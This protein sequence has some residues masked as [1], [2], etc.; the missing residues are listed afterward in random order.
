MQEL[1]LID[2]SIVT[3]NSS[4]WLD[5]FFESLVK[6]NYP[7]DKI[8]IY[9]RDNGSTDNTFEFCEVI[10]KQYANDFHVIKLSQ[11]KN[12]GFGYGHNTNLKISDS[13]Y[14]LVTNVDL[15][16]EFNSIQEIVITALRDSCN[17]ASWEFR[18][19]PYEHPKYYNPVTLE[20]C[21]SSSACILFR[22]SALEKVGGYEKR[23][24]M[25]GEDVELSYRLRDKGYKLKYCPKAVCWHYTYDENQFKLVQFHGSTLANIYIRIRYGTYSEIVKAILMYLK[26]FIYHCGVIKKVGLYRRSYLWYL[27]KSYI[28]RVF[29]VPI[30]SLSNSSRKENWKKIKSN[31]SILQGL[32][33]NG[34]KLFINA[35]YFFLTRKKSQ[36]YFP[37]SAW[38]YELNR[39]GA[40]YYH[41][42]YQ[43]KILPLVSI[44]VRTYK[45]RLNN[46]LEAV[47][48]ILN[49]TYSNLELIVIEDGSSEAEEN[50][51]QIKSKNI[52]NKVIYESIPKSGRCI[53]GNRGLEL[54]NGDYICFLDDDDLFF[55]DHVETLAGELISNKNIA[56]VYSLAFQIG[57]N[58][59][60]ATTIGGKEINSKIPYKKKFSRPLLWHSNFIP[61]QSLLFKKEL[62]K[63]YG[64]F[65]SSLEYLE[66]WNLWV[67]YSLKHD[68]ILVEKVTSMY[69]VPD[70]PQIALNRQKFL[71]EYYHVALS[72]YSQ[73]KLE[74]IT[75]ASIINYC[76][77]FTQG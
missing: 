38:D 77:E 47:S 39:E 41:P 55:A 51:N 2:I 56:G 43:L 59:L 12:K 72:R 4:R 73:M 42:D 9:I 76:K 35:P 11:G 62:Y 13:D 70:D 31:F 68:F 45:G 37:F 64:G 63:E 40:S 26:L 16:F 33:K 60:L 48:S 65:D 30:S 17:I 66:D 69:R 27:I 15:E 32:I 46:L 44:I 67:R 50:I 14:F 21:W 61:I 22:R 57:T 3:Y 74:N 75:I 20:T 7:T 34:F 36:N 6:Q 52:L 58:K 54:A 71:D 49:Q 10:S 24:F 53:A 19:K 28:N 5:N 29:S 23:I 1:P 8:N 18:Q 25:Y